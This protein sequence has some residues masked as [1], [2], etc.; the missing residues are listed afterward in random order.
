MLISTVG[1]KWEKISAM[2][3]FCTSKTKITIKV[4]NQ[5]CRH[6]MLW[7]EIESIF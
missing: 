2:K 5:T 6:C 4:I 7:E 1:K 3:F